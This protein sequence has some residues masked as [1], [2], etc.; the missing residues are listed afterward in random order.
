MGLGAFGDPDAQRAGG[1]VKKLPLIS[2]KMAANG[3]N[4]FVV[5]AA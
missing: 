3:N 2:H 4:A 1:N 5:L